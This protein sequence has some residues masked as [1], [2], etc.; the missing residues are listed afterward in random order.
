MVS[1]HYLIGL[2]LHYGVEKLGLFQSEY[3]EIVKIFS[4]N[5]NAEWKNSTFSKILF[6]NFAK[7]VESQK[8]N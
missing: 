8:P 5:Y 2:H 7:N 1:N 4:L 3:V 6:R